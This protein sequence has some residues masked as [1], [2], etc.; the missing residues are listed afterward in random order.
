MPRRV[1]ATLALACA[2]L[3][4]VQAC[5]AGHDGGQASQG[6][7]DA[8]DTP[9]TSPSTDGGGGDAADDQAQAAQAYLRIAHLSP[10]MPAIDVCIAPHGTT[11]FQGPLIGQLAADLAGD[12]EAGA[13]PGVAYSQVSAYVPVGLGQMD[14]RIVA[15]GATACSAP[16][17]ALPDT[18]SL[19]ALAVDTY[20]TLLVAGDLLSA[21]GDQ[22]VTVVMLPDDAVLAGGAASLRAVNAVPSQP[23]LDF[24]MASLPDASPQWM[25]LLEDVAFAGVSTRANPDDGAVDSKGYLAIEPF[26]DQPMVARASS[27]DATLA[28]AVAN[29][30][31]IT[32]GSVA[33]VFAIG[34]KTGDTAHPPAL[35]LCNDIQP[36]GG[37][38]ADCSIAH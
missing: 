23:A 26:S 30:V 27:S 8:G 5:S 21:G 20:T 3:P 1:A 10:D 19:P 33:T 13:T 29:S 15:A 17:A 7:N 4:L 22:G 25:A 32:V 9:E 28:V 6:S 18:T 16:L 11:S 31:T 14:V 34:G 12:A 38:L 2:A 24:G 37:I 35:L 36:S